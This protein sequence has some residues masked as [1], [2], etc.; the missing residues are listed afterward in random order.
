MDA[1]DTTRARFYHSLSF[2]VV[3]GLIVAFIVTISPFFYLQHTRQR[4]EL[5]AQHIELA[6]S[7]SNIIKAGLRHGMMTRDRGALKAMLD[8]LGHQGGLVRV[9]VLDKTGTIKASQQ[10]EDVGTQLALTEPT[11]QLC[12]SSEAEKRSKT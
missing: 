3:F 10:P 7:Q 9:W 11:C 5:I 6:T 1:D 8:S 2:K 4:A 12:H